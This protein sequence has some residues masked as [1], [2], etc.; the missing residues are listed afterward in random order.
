MTGQKLID[1]INAHGLN[2]FPVKAD[3]GVL[4]FELARYYDYEVA[5]ECEFE[6][7]VEARVYVQTGDLKI[8]THRNVSCDLGKERREI[9]DLS[10]NL[11]KA[12]AKCSKEISE[13]WSTF[14][15][16]TSEDIFAP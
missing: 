13:K 3:D 15:K 2:K 4:V 9:Y 10:E 16:S 12:I 1:F 7:L 6:E 8:E 14:A 11:S 5:S